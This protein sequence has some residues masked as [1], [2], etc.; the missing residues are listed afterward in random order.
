VPLELLAGKIMAQLA[1]RNILVVDVEIHEFAKKKI[2]YKETPDGILIKNKKYSFDEGTIVSQSENLD[3]T[4][5]NLDDEN[6][7]EACVQSVLKKLLANPQMHSMLHQA[8]AKTP[9]VNIASQ[10]A[11]SAIRHEVFNPIDK[12]F[13][14]DAKNRKLSFTLGKKYAILKERKAANEMVGMLYTVD[15]DNGKRHSLSDKFFTPDVTLS[16]FGKEEFKPAAMAKSV[17][18]DGLDWSSF[19]DSNIP[20]IRR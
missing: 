5:E 7:S 6:M 4:N 20:D 10:P 1:R 18:G 15:D 9:G 14:E 11:S 2:S 16:N 17:T 3:D 8:G 13:I 12:I 19:T